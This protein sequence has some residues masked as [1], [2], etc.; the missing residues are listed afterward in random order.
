MRRT[1]PTREQIR[2]DFRK[3]IRDGPH[4]IDILD[5]CSPNEH[6]YTS[7]WRDRMGN[8]KRRGDLGYVT[9]YALGWKDA[10]KNIRMN[11][12]QSTGESRHLRR[13][14]RR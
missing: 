5:S 8:T 1:R 10:D 7:G 4:I 13:R 6:E 12:A 2:E 3:Q 14:A 11:R 9:A